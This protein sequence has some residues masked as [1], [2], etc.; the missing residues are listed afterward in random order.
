[1]QRQGSGGSGGRRFPRLAK[2]ASKDKKG[3]QKNDLFNAARDFFRSIRLLNQLNATFLSLIPKNV[4]AST[5]KD[6]RPMILCNMVYK[7][8]SKILVLLSLK[9]VLG[10]M[11][12]PN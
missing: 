4:E 6:Y 10:K 9:P 3:K 8:F 11:I 1:M 7:I 12:A 2:V 5:M